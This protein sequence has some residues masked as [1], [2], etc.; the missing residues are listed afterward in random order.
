MNII[1]GESIEIP[2][3]FKGDQ[4]FRHQAYLLLKRDGKIIKNMFERINL[5]KS[6]RGGQYKMI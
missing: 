1:E 3:N 6:D 4:L 5:I 2:V